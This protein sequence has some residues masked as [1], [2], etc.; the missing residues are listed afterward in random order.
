MT[1]SGPVLLPPLEREDAS[2][3]AE[4]SLAESSAESVSEG[5]PGESYPWMGLGGMGDGSPQR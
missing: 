4:D 5:E 1:P 2:L 3:P